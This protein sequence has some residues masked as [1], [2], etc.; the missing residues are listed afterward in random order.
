MK[1]NFMML[2]CALALI[3][4]PVIAFVFLLIGNTDET[5][6][7]ENIGFGCSATGEVD[8][9]KWNETFAKSGVF[10]EKGAKFIQ[11]AQKQGIDPVLFAAIAFNETGYGTSNAVV[12]KNNPGGLM[13]IAT[14]MST[15][16]VFATLD[17]GIEAMGVTLHNRIIKDQLNT[18]EKLGKV[19]A[20][21][22]VANDPNGMNLNWIPTVTGIVE[23]LGGLT[24]NCSADVVGT[25][26][27]MI[28]VDNPVVT[29]GF[30][31]R[32]GTLHKGIDFGQPI[33]TP[34]KASDAGVVVVTMHMAISGS[35]FGG[36]GNVIE[37]QHGNEFTLY[38]HLSEIGVSVGQK[39]K[40]GDVIGKVG[41]TGNSTG[42]HLHFEIRKQQM[43]G[44]VDPA[45]ILGIPAP[46]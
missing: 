18:I 46:Q 11:E 28:P 43:G 5:S 23:K 37:I 19:Y 16:K 15:V 26:K 31:A 12:N 22:G 13:D 34:V 9:T 3:L 41:N 17:E 39:V 33:G 10:K 27:Y 21:I 4:F 29:S 36:Y 1:L 30:G 42:P 44:Q 38:G 6:E 40:Q 24:M 20:P 32:W 8:M 7:I 25:G 2:V 45:P 35:G 14:G